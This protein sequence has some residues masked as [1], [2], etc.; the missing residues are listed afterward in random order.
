MSWI[1]KA[2]EDVKAS[3]ARMPKELR[4]AALRS[5]TKDTLD[6]SAWNDHENGTC[7]CYQS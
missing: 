4:C 2:I 5:G 6:V 3:V 1:E 7:G